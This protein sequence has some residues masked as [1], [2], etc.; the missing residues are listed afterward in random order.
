MKRVFA[1]L[2]VEGAA[3]RGIQGCEPQPLWI[4]FTYTNSRHDLESHCYAHRSARDVIH[5]MLIARRFRSIER[6]G[7][8]LE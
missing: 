7:H 3:G 5:V 2:A 4:A 8:G 1:G 6:I